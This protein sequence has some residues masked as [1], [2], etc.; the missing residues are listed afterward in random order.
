MQKRGHMRRV[1]LRT[2]SL[3]YLVIATASV[4][5]LAGAQAT[6]G[7][8]LD[9]L[10]SIESLTG[11]SF[12]DMLF[13]N[14]AANRL[15]GGGGNDTLNGDPGN[16]VLIGGTGSDVFVFKTSVDPNNVDAIEDFE[17]GVEVIHL[18]SPVF[19]AIASLGALAAE[20]FNTGAEATDIDDRII[21]DEVT[22]VLRYDSDGAGGADAVQFAMLTNVA[23]VLSENDFLVI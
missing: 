11:S 16:D 9:Q 6:G 15:M 23:T 18:S 21:Y 10:V 20:A 19:S 5:I 22:G 3:S 1:G 12:G 17:V 2:N 4:Q 7:S 8:G 14:S 13:G